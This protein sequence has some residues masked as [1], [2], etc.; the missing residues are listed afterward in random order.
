MAAFGSHNGVWLVFCRISKPIHKTFA[1][2]IN[3]IF[4]DESLN[5]HWFQSVE[6]TRQT[7]VACRVEYFGRRPLRTLDQQMLVACAFAWATLA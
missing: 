5:Q 3:G 2:S 1:E 7:I 4:R 6:G